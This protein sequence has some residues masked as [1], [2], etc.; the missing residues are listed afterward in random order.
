M[1]PDERKITDQEVAEILRINLEGDD[2]APYPEGVVAR[3]CRSWRA[4][5]EEIGRH[6][7]TDSQLR[8]IKG[9]CLEHGHDF[10]ETTYAIMAVI[11]FWETMRL[12]KPHAS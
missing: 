5:G 4:R 2:P 3:L 7:P 9:L 10:G 1:P 6:E 8:R 12:E 11:Q